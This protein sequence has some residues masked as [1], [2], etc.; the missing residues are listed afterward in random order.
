MLDW[1]LENQMTKRYD[2]VDLLVTMM[3]LIMAAI[4]FIFFR[5]SHQIHGLPL[6]YICLFGA[7]L[8]FYNF[9]SD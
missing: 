1:S 3:C 5:H 9:I 4:T 2:P 6:F 8:N 7:G